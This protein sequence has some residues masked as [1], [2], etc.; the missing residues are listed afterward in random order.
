MMHSLEARAPLLDVE[1]VEH[2]AAMPTRYKMHRGQLKVLLKHAFSSTLPAPIIKRPKKGFGIP[3]ADWIKG[4]LR[5]WVEELF[6]PASLARHGV[7]SSAGV[8]RVWGDHLSGARDN[9][10]VLWSLIVLMLWMEE[11]L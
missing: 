9:R 7:F 4:P 1:V 3:V 10:K 8:Q 6:S 11:N 2:F 5:P